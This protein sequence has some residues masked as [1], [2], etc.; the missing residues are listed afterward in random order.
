MSEFCA[1]DNGGDIQPHGGTNCSCGPSNL[2]TRQRGECVFRQGLGACGSN[3][4]LRGGKFTL[5]EGGTRSPAFIHSALLPAHTQGQKYTG[6]LHVSD[7]YVTLAKRAGIDLSIKDRPTGPVPH[8]GI[9]AWPALSN[10]GRVGAEPG[11]RLLFDSKPVFEVRREA[12][13]CGNTSWR[14]GEADKLDGAV[15]VK[16]NDSYHYKLIIASSTSFVSNAGWQPLPP[17]PYEPPTND[18]ICDKYCVFDLAADPTE[19]QNLARTPAGLKLLEFL[20][21]RYQELTQE[22]VPA[23]APCA[24][25]TAAEVCTAI[26]GKNRGHFGPF[27]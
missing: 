10:I 3:A 13:I 21:G 16:H 20:L 24:D 6:L 9:D 22:R 5:F 19:R 23:D 17:K 7:W 2:C 8:D 25:C 12:L 27:R 4:P 1:G 11:S 18:S 14:L 26:Q 15:V